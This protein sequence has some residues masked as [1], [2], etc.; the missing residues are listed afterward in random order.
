MPPTT[1]IN[2]FP[3]VAVVMARLI[4]D[5]EDHGARPFIVWLNDGKNMFDGI[6]SKYVSSTLLSTSL[7]NVQV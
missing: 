7:G 2:G 3:R 6:T 1:P 4:V 5:G